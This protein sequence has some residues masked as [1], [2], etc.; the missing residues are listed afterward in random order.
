LKSPAYKN[1]N[2]KPFCDYTVEDA[3]RRTYGARY[4]MRRHSGKRKEEGM[5]A[6][7]VKN[8]GLFGSKA[9]GNTKTLEKDLALSSEEREI[10]EALEDLKRELNILYSQFNFFTDPSLID[11][12]IYNIKAANSKYTFYLNQCKERQ[13]K[14]VV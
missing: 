9:D 12:C 14:A 13:I 1:W 10:I 7:A 4:F 11:G 5:S 8:Q 2:K 6:I 3:H